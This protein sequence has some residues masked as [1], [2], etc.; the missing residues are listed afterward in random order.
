M[1]FHF[2]G[3][4]DPQDGCSLWHDACNDNSHDAE[5]AQTLKCASQMLVVANNT[6][7]T[8]CIVWLE[9]APT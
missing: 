4:L 8:V 7:T 3:A 6:I 5:T 1:V 9:R 2:S